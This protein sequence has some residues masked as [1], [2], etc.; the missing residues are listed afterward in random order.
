MFPDL[1]AIGGSV[2]DDGLWS[3]SF[4]VAAADLATPI[5]ATVLVEGVQ[6]CRWWFF[7]ICLAYD[8]SPDLAARLIDPAG[9][10]LHQSNC[11]LVGDCGAV[12]L[13][14]TVYAMPTVADS[15]RLEVYPN[16]AD[17]NLGAGGDFHVSLSNGMFGAVEVT[18]PAPL[19]G[20]WP[21]D[22]GTGVTAADASGNGYDATLVNGPSW[23]LGRVGGGLTFDGVDDRV[24]V[25]GAAL[26]GLRDATV[27]LWVRT[28]KTGPQALL[29]AAGPGDDNELLLFLSS[30][31]ELQFFTGESSGAFVSWT[32]PTL[33]DGAWHHL[34]VLRDQAAGTVSLYRDGALEGTQATA[35][36]RL[37]VAAAGVVLGQEQDAVGGGF[38]PAQALAGSLDEVYVYRRVLS[39]S[40]IVDLASPALDATPPTAPSGLAAS[41]GAPAIQLDWSPADDPESGVAAYRIHRA[42]SSGGATTLL[43][44][45]PAAQTS[46]VDASATPETT[47]FYTVTAVNGHGVEGPPSNE[48]SG[49]AGPDLLGHWT[50]DD[51]AGSIAADGSGYGHDGTLLNGPAWTSGR[52][53]GALGFDGND[54]RVDLPAAALDGLADASLTLWLQTTKPGMQGLVSA[55]NAG[56]DNELLLFLASGSELRFYSG[57]NGVTFVSWTV[58]SL[59]DG[60]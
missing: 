17:P 34:A 24:D 27:A 39:E 1:V 9:A 12:G 29:S 6:T 26:D 25:P 22:D 31:T 3:M 49:S 28:T 43:T 2:P 54:D 16:D 36:N 51:G 57:E 47:Y 23:D 8:W 45:L 46:H 58:P 41:N 38:D 50:L 42:T 52:L 7:G 44:E 30:D 13:Q 15:Y 53:G 11:T 19:A 35:L 55:A 56:N 32:V 59:A 33:A 4:D 48:A 21:L 37:D 60:T 20:Y 5:A 40:E 18:A 10:V 14:E